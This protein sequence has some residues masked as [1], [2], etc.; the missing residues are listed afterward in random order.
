MK[1]S[2]LRIPF[3]SPSHQM[4]VDTFTFTFTV[5]VVSRTGLKRVLEPV[6]LVLLSFLHVS[7]FLRRMNQ[8]FLYQ[9]LVGF[10]IHERIIVGE[11]TTAF[12]WAASMK[13]EPPLWVNPLFKT[14]HPHLLFNKKRFSNSISFYSL[15]FR[16]SFCNIYFNSP[17]PFHLTS[18]GSVMTFSFNPNQDPT[19]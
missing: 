9:H 17:F 5:D 14:Q 8:R 13:F 7:D 16:F 15:H 12:V 1:S 18:R 10:V 6:Q 19:L 2:R 11:L 3:A 4:V